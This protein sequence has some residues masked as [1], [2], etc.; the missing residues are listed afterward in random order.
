VPL[1][2]GVPLVLGLFFTGA[3]IFAAFLIANLVGVLF[4]LGEPGFGLFA[5]SIFDTAT[6]TALATIPLFIL[7]GEILFRSGSVEILLESVEQ[8]VGRIRGRQFIL[9]VV[10]AVIFGALSGAAMGV[11]A[12]LA[13]SLYPSMVQMGYSQRMSAGTILAGASLAPIIPPSVLVIII[14]SIADVSIARMLIAG[15]VP[16]VLMAII[17]LVYILGRVYLDSSLAPIDSGQSG[18]LGFGEAMAALGRTLPFLLVIFAVLG[19]VLSGIATPSE[20][21]AT[22]VIGALLVA[23]YYRKLTWRMVWES[24]RSAAGIASII[25]VIMASSKMFTQLLAFTGTTQQMTQFV[26]DLGLHP[27]AM[28]FIM[29][30][31]PFVLCMFVDQIALL[32]IIIPVYAPLLGPL[33]FDPIW[34]WIIMLINVTVGGMTPPFGYTMFAFKGA[35]PDVALNDIFAAAWPFVGLFVLGM[36][37]LATFPALVTFLPGLM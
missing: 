32:L 15:I 18:S 30:A 14:G 5:N 2:I 7:I 25:L 28:L 1:A 8:L 29:L 31:L 6:T 21:G 3:P 27:A 19:V 16:G 34:F 9:A 24:T 20:S 26:A 22:G 36:V 4:L 11:V 13:R 33:G 35:A 17:F 23:A 12:M 10:L 37:I